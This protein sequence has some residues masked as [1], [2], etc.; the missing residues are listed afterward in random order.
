MIYST[1][2]PDLTGFNDAEFVK[3][4]SKLPIVRQDPPHN[5]NIFLPLAIVYRLVRPP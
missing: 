1:I 4:D 5:S 3:I 2:V